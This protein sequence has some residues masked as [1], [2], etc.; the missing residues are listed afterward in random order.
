[1]EVA[2][3]K[4]VQVPFTLVALPQPTIIDDTHLEVP[5]TMAKIA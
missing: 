3:G 5:V 1:M 2:E 4:V